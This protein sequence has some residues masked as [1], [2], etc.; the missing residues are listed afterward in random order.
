MVI[1]ILRTWLCAIVAGS[2]SYPVSWWYSANDVDNSGGG[3]A[4]MMEFGSGVEEGE[5]GK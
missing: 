2:C 3:T 1:V 5:R 4:A